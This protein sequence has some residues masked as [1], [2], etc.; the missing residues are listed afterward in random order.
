MKIGLIDVD[1]HNFPNL[2]LMKISAYHKALGDNVSMYEPLFNNDCEKIY[3]SKIFSFTP[4]IQYVFCDNVIK[5]GS[6]YDLSVT[7]PEEIDNIYPD[8]SLYNIKDTAYGYLT[9][10]CF[11]NCA[12]CIVS[13][14]EG[15]KTKQIYKLNQFYKNQKIIKLLDPNITAAANCIDLFNELSETG[16]LVDFTQGLDLRLLTDEKIEAVKKIKLKMI[17]FAWDKIEDEKIICE[18]LSVFM[19]ETK[20]NYHKVSVYILVNFN[21]TFEQDLHRVYKIRDMGASPY[22]M[23]YE[24]EK[25]AKKYC[26]LQRYVNAMPIFRTIKTFD[27]YKR[28]S[29]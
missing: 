21:T 4:D 5:G 18:R 17:H 2:A 19:N 7:L 20:Y 1:S 9:R 14:K 10:G 12:F 6:G 29:V 25:A 23:I 24:K 16:A 3:I 26:H 22:I 11:R 8:Y 27:E 13:K 15:I 28:K